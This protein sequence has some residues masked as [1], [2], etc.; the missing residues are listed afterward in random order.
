MEE[1]IY[2]Y[3]SVTSSKP[4]K[5]A[6]RSK[7]LVIITIFHM[8]VSTFFHPAAVLHDVTRLPIQFL[9]ACVASKTYIGMYV[10]KNEKRALTSFIY[11]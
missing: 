4:L 8:I 9:D 3:Q 11:S 1:M 2:R 7:S 5:K 6:E 10:N